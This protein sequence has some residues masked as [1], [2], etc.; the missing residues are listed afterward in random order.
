MTPISWSLDSQAR[1][2]K[3]KPDS[4]GPIRVN[5]IDDTGPSLESFM[6]EYVR[7]PREISG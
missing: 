6:A 4:R 2:G 1:H 3:I 5:Q 7:K